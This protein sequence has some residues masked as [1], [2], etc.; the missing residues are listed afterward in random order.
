MPGAN[1]TKGTCIV[2]GQ[3]FEMLPTFERIREKDGMIV[4]HGDVAGRGKGELIVTSAGK[5]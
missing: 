4:Y 5:V 1:M 2:R 3:V